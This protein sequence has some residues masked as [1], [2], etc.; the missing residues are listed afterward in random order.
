M[1]PC[2]HAR[3]PTAKRRLCIKRKCKA[4]IA[5]KAALMHLVKQ[6]SCNPGKFGISLD[7]VAKYAFSQDKDTCCSAV[8]AVHARGIANAFANG[9]PRQFG[10]ALSRSARR[11]ATR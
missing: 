2:L 9:F 10:H 8:P 4:K 5:V 1:K 3:R 6:N 11:Q 7:T